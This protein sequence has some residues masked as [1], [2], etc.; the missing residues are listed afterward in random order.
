MD[1]NERNRFVD[2]LLDAS[3]A[4]YRGVEPRPGLQNRILAQ[5][6]GESKALPYWT[7][8]RRIGAGLV[9]A[10]VILALVSIAYRRPPP[11]PVS[12]TESPKPAGT[13]GFGVRD[14]GFGKG[15]EPRT[16]KSETRISPS[17]V[18]ASTS[19]ATAGG[20]RRRDVLSRIP[21]PG[22]QTPSFEPRRDVF[23]SPA[24]LSE[25]EKLL[26]SYVRQWPEA[27]LAAFPED[28]QP[29]AS[30]KVPDLKIPPLEMKEA[31]ASTT[32]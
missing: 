21:N 10:G 27:A 32:D 19:H 31:S 24:P 30:L 29:V 5:L 11:A 14:S 15:H 1:E 3:L 2:D 7:W 12:V 18:H 8:P 17:L 4:R 20:E 23:P 6:R 22:P 25:E 16:A 26:V 9:A 13:A 28:G